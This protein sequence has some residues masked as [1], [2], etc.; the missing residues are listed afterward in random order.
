[1]VGHDPGDLV[2]VGQVVNGPGGEEL[3]ESCGAEGRMAAATLQIGGLK[4]QG[5]QLAQAFR[6]G[7]REFV[8]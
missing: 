5:A 3:R 1:L 6:A 2:Q 7:A 8:E 4:I